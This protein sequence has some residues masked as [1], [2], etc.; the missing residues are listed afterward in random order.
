MPTNINTSRARHALRPR[1][2]V[3]RPDLRFREN[4]VMP[5]RE[6]G[7]RQ[8]SR[9]DELET[10]AEEWLVADDVPEDNRRFRHVEARYEGQS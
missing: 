7:W 9:F 4:I 3:I 2:F 5:G 6:D 10:Q 1:H 8:A